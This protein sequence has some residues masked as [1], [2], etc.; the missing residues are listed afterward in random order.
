[1]EGNISAEGTPN[2][3]MAR[4]LRVWLGLGSPR[5]RHELPGAESRRRDFEE[6][7]AFPA[8]QFSLTSR[9]PWR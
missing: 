4:P 6:T 8:N 5:E 1:M 2:S 7:D 3:R 9:N